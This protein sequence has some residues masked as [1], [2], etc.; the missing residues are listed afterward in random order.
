MVFPTLLLGRHFGAL[1]LLPVLLVFGT[2]AA[3]LPVLYAGV[4][5]ALR[6]ERFLVAAAEADVATTG[7]PALAWRT[8]DRQVG[9]A[10]TG[11]P[12]SESCV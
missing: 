1:G 8:T 3:F 5:R 6:R 11:V 2:G 7:A 4:S 12:S 10:W 9:Q